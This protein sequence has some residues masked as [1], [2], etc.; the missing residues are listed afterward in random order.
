[1]NRHTRRSLRATAKATA[2][3]IAGKFFEYDDTGRMAR[4]TERKAIA[5]LADAFEALLRGGLRPCVSLISEAEAMAFPSWKST[6]AGMTHAMAVGVDVAGFATSC[7]K[8]AI[9]VDKA[10]GEVDV[11]ASADAAMA[12]ALA[13]L[14]KHR[15]FAGFPLSCFTRTEGRA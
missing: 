13:D 8:S 15:S 6:N 5:L 4:V 11:A 1:M 3:T 2:A 14:D 9:A 12:R 7:T 10:T